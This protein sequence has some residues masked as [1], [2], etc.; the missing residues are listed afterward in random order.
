MQKRPEN[1][2]TES[3]HKDIAIIGVACRFPG[4][5]D[6]DQFWENLASG[7]TSIEEIPSER[8]RWQ[9][10]YDWAD[11]STSQEQGASAQQSKA[12]T[13]GKTKVKYAGFIKDMDKFDAMFFGVPPREAEFMD[14]QHRI[15]LECA[16]HA[17]ENA[18]YRVS[19][20]AESQ[21]GVYCGVSKND[22]TEL[23]REHQIDIEPYVSTGTVHSLI[24][25]RVSFLMNLQGPSEVVDTACS[26][27]LVALR[28]AVQDVQLGLCDGAIVG[29]VNAILSPTMILSHSRSGM[30]AIDGEIKTFDE[31]ADGYVRG[32]GVA[33][34][35]IKPLQEAERDGDPIWGVIKSVAVNHSGR[36]NF[37]TSPS[38]SGQARVIKQA[39]E[40]SGLDKSAI[41]YIE[42]HGTGTK[43]GDPI[44]IEGLKLAFADET[45][46]DKALSDKKTDSTGT[47]ALGSAKPNI[48]HLE[49]VAGLAG[50]IKILLSMKHQLLP[51]LANFK[52]KNPYIDL[53]N[54]G[55]HL[56]EDAEIWSASSGPLT[57]GLSSFGM[58]GVNAHVI[59]QQYQAQQYRLPVEKKPID[60]PFILPFSAKKGQLRACVEQYFDAVSSATQ[61]LA[62]DL[63]IKQFINNFS[64]TLRHGR[65][66]MAQRVVLIVNS[67]DDLKTAMTAV[68]S[69]ELDAG[70]LWYNS[71]ATSETLLRFSKSWLAAE[72]GVDMAQAPVSDGKSIPLP[73]YAFARRRC[74]YPENRN[75]EKS[76]NNAV[77]VQKKSLAAP[78]PQAAIAQTTSVSSASAQTATRSVTINLADDWFYLSQHRIQGELVMPG[79]AHFH[80][81][82]EALWPQSKTEAGYQG[83]SYEFCDVYWLRAWLS[84]QNQQLLLSLI[85]L[86]DNHYS[87][88]I[89]DGQESFVK[90]TVRRLSCH[91]LP[92][93]AYDSFDFDQVK[94]TASIYQSLRDYGI[95]H[96][97]KFQVLHSIQLSPQGAVAQAK[98]RADQA[99]KVIAL[100]PCMIDG[101][102]QVVT[103][104]DI[105]PSANSEAQ[106]VPFMLERGCFY[107]P[108]TKQC[109]I[110]VNNDQAQTGKLRQ[111]SMSIYDQKRQV[112]AEFFGFKKKRLKSLAEQQA[113]P[114]SQMRPTPAS[115]AQPI[116]A[117][118]LAQPQSDNEISAGQ[119]HYYTPSWFSQPQWHK[120]ERQGR[121]VLCSPKPLSQTFISNKLPESWLVITNQ[122]PSSSAQHNGPARHYYATFGDEKNMQAVFTDI[123]AHYQ[124]IDAVIYLLADAVQENLLQDR[125]LVDNASS[126]QTVLDENFYC[127]SLTKG[128]I[129]AKLKQPVKLLCC[130]NDAAGSLPLH[131][132]LA[133]FARTLAYEYPKISMSLALLEQALF[134]EN[135]PEGLLQHIS[136]ELDFISPPMQLLAYRQGKRYV[137]LMRSVTPAMREFKVEAAGSFAS[138]N[139]GVIVIYGGAGGLGRIFSEYL[140]AHSDFPIALVG[141]RPLNDTIRAFLVEHNQSRPR[142]AYFSADVTDAHQVE[143][144]LRQVRSDLGRISGIIY[145]AGIIEDD[146]ILRK[147]LASYKKVFATKVLG[148]IHV[149]QASKDDQLDF[150]IAFSSIAALMPNQGQADYASGNAFLDAFMHQRN[151][152]RQQ[153]L[154]SG[155]S[156]AINW[157]LWKNGGMQV[158]EEEVRHLLDVFGMKPLQTE[159]G[160]DLFK[161]VISAQWANQGIEN[162]VLI[163]GDKNKIDQHLKPADSS[164]T[165]VVLQATQA[166]LHPTREATERAA[167]DVAQQDRL[168]KLRYLI[169]GVL[170][171]LL[172]RIVTEPEL[173]NT[174]SELG[175]DSA[176][177]V[178][179]VEAFCR[180]LPVALNPAQLFIY[181][182]PKSLAEFIAKRDAEQLRAYF[183]TPAEAKTG[184]NSLID[185][186]ASDIARGEFN[187]TISTQEFYMQGHIYE[188]KYN[189][190]GACYVEMAFQAAEPFFAQKSSASKKVL[191]LKNVSFLKRL[192]SYGEPVSIRLNIGKM[193][194][195]DKS[196]DYHIAKIEDDGQASVCSQGRIVSSDFGGYPQLTHLL[197]KHCYVKQHEE[198]VQQLIDEGDLVD[199]AFIAAQNVYVQDD[200]ALGEISL[201]ADIVD[202]HGDFILH[203]ALLAG[204]MQTS[205]VLNHPQKEGPFKHV[206]PM[207][208][209]EITVYGR[210]PKKCYAYARK[211]VRT[212]GQ[213]RRFD[214]VIA[215]EN[216]QVLVEINGF[217]IKEGAV[218]ATVV[219][220]PPAEITPVNN[221]PITAAAEAA[222]Q[223]FAAMLDELKQLLAPLLGMALDELDASASFES[224]INNS[225]VIVELNR[226][227]ERRF[228]SLSKTL[229]FEYETLNELAGYFLDLAQASTAIT[230]P[231]TELPQP[232]S[233]P[234]QVSA[235]A[236]K[237]L[238]MVS[239]LTSVVA[240]VL[241]F[242]EE[243]I[244]T[245]SSFEDYITNSIA[246]VEIN[247]QLEERFGSLSK[248]LLFEYENIDDLADYFLSNHSEANESIAQVHLSSAHDNPARAAEA[249]VKVSARAVASSPLAEAI[250]GL[251]QLIGPILGVEEHELDESASFEDYISNSI[252][253]VE[254]NT[255]LEAIYGQLS[256][257]L[258]FEYENIRELAQYFH[259]STELEEVVEKVAEEKSAPRIAQH[260]VDPKRYPTL[261]TLGHEKAGQAQAFPLTDMQ[262]SFMVGRELSKAYDRVGCHIYCEF[263]VD[264]LDVGLLNMAWNR[265]IAHHPMLRCRIQADGSQAFMNQCPRFDITVDDFRALN[266]AQKRT[267]LEMKRDSLS[268]RVYDPLVWPLFDIT[269]SQLNESEARVHFSADELILDGASWHLLMK[270]WR[271]L[272]DNPEAELA[273][274]QINFSDW[275]VAC[276]HFEKSDKY[277]QD[278]DYWQQKLERMPAG[279]AL[280]LMEPAPYSSQQKV[281][282]RERLSGSL[283]ATS[284]TSIK[285][286]AK[287]LHISYTAIVLAK[288]VEVLSRKNGGRA[289]PLLMTYLNRPP[290]HS[291]L[292]QIIGPFISSTVFLADQHGSDFHDRAKQT[293]QQ[294]WED[295][296]HVSVSGTKA[297]R[298]CQRKKRKSY[299]IPVVFT[300]FLGVIDDELHGWQDQV[301]YTI[302]QTPQVYWDHQMLERE[303]ALD[304]SW[305]VVIEYFPANALYEAFTAFTQALHLLARQA[306]GQQTQVVGQP[307]SIA[308]GK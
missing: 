160:L 215:D 202:T 14:P 56:L 254:I 30:L 156:S 179:F 40:A 111:Y 66:Q 308:E 51:G 235:G 128:L 81:V 233:A 287:S 120:R 121:V 222:K 270:Q 253:I 220:A 86:A 231:L 277:Q 145:A 21:T 280:P 296:E 69:G 268:H 307:R 78:K 275:V 39:I 257:T 12:S 18:G 144:S 52:K 204:F 304:F 205:R 190:P 269:V 26:S 210:A 151:N 200:E 113:E 299:F 211:Q 195:K 3:L 10:Y 168:P 28:R 199:F 262:Q 87:Y 102:F 33:A 239:M 47:C 132:S 27:S 146:F 112:L 252:V 74:W 5:Q 167:P 278:L 91:A 36:A 261:K 165:P 246:I 142:L 172:T 79:A 247:R 248:T 24:A 255:R 101:V 259:G 238:R 1:S 17:V 139:T 284:W 89:S 83:L 42:C 197:D 245:G 184:Q 193:Q 65:D 236:D 295:L 189:F 157:P 242:A 123:E 41:S 96:G 291:D 61:S 141:R 196:Y 19:R 100:N 148:A 159:L 99:E 125:P 244:D 306:Q 186:R 9:D 72:S 170:G 88:E 138:G 103:Q 229:L 2:V 73:G 71:A 80:L 227:L 264:H 230:S 11:K 140:L 276:K 258:L 106:F 34:I 164:L 122:Q 192:S 305:D 7:I 20:L 260:I 59:I 177:L 272:Y 232:A 209:D 188:G 282:I 68:I 263:N 67:I 163:D 37:L 48:G 49:P 303:G 31:S 267:R 290:I 45:F 149:D 294:L 169:R 293:H 216:G 237:R 134:D 95:N 84:E 104:L 234:R 4:A 221:N 182:T 176:S 54:T 153:G 289:F 98:Y 240:K 228:G 117:Q 243:E 70:G 147:K 288:F 109:F 46:S 250:A 224:Y 29:G 126:Q 212:Q 77:A 62:D 201:H 90:G 131:H 43:L 241:G 300:S 181:D 6:Y 94:S 223:D 135:Q 57:A 82:T 217:A 206:I 152:W 273:H 226:Q 92:K 198:V 178:E 203:P 22:Y 274:T 58:G 155:Y 256:K 214:G 194:A 297:L 266:D 208:I 8:W 137:Q 25:N 154:R 174:F 219:K 171:G 207:A 108:L 85:A 118:Q 119:L 271:Y 175:I 15:F 115:P 143:Q 191:T 63:S 279:Q 249:P 105:S 180:R 298:E 133:G 136:Q 185:L 116:P 127:L 285:C 114:L 213:I 251:K 218:K 302:T 44:E 292:T 225:I 60:N 76:K 161:S 183:N 187:K 53:Q 50:L 286:L 13:P 173:D 32:E 281:F 93:K 75:T 301:S 124:A 64:H 162:I 107:Q 55:F 16:W 158:K 130:V 23:M 166:P 150:F 38:A 35:Y 97:T 283:D 129:R 265:L 110:Q